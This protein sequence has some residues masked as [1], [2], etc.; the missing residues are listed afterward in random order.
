MGLPKPVVGVDRSDGL[1]GGAVDHDARRRTR[2][3]DE[4]STAADDRS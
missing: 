2:I 3:S 4:S 1:I